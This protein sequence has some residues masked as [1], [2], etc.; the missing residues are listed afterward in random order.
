M[1]D[2]LGGV[3]SGCGKNMTMK[4]AYKPSKFGH[5]IYIKFKGMIEQGRCEIF[6][7]E[8]QKDHPELK[9]IGKSFFPQPLVKYLI[10]NLYV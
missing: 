7:A 10:H 8:D 1:S 3:K 4:W 2:G 9:N 5:D 6:C